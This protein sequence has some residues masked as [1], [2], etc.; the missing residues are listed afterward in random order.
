[1]ELRSQHHQP[2]LEAME[3]QLHT[4]VVH[5][6]QLLTAWADALPNEPLELPEPF[7]QEMAGSQVVR[8]EPE[9]IEIDAA[10]LALLGHPAAPLRTSALKLMSA[11][12]SL[13]YAR[14]AAYDRTVS[15]RLA[16]LSSSHGQVEAS[17]NPQELQ[18]LQARITRVELIEGFAADVI[19]A[20]ASSMSRR[21]S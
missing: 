4:V 5:V 7:A 18:E 13:F 2:A 15:D 11:T 3:A 6:T 20:A 21:A 9:L 17:A 16:V 19:D 1:M 10:A 8:I 14:K 12:R